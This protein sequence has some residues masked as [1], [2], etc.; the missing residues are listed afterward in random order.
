MMEWDFSWFFLIS[1]PLDIQILEMAWA[2]FPDFACDMD[3]LRL[4]HGFLRGSASEFRRKTISNNK[5]NGWNIMK[6]GDLISF[7]DQT[8]KYKN[9]CTS[10]PQMADSIPPPTHF[11][12]W[13]AMSTGQV[14][15]G[16]KG[17]IYIFTIFHARPDAAHVVPVVVLVRHVPHQ[18]QKEDGLKVLQFGTGFSH[19]YGLC[20]NIFSIVAHSILYK[21]RELPWYPVSHE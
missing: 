5:S 21:Y 18:N 16:C 17:S 3:L 6:L 8:K 13:Y 12:P 9:Y 2:G 4:G 14:M 19:F 15:P 11:L 10:F 7:E 1:N 20:L